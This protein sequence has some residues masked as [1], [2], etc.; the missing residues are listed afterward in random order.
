M[1]IGN[2]IN[3]GFG[4][5][6]KQLKFYCWH[7]K[8]DLD[9]RQQQELV[10]LLNERYFEKLASK[11]RALTRSNID[12]CK[13][14]IAKLLFEQCLTGR[15]RNQLIQ[16]I[17]SDLVDIDVRLDNYGRTLLHRT[18]YNLDVELVKLL[19]DHGVNIRLRDYAGNSALHIAIQSYRNGALIFNNEP[20]V[21]QNLTSI[22]K[23][24]LDA[25]R[26]SQRR[27]AVQKRLK[28]DAER[29]T[30]NEQRHIIKDPGSPKI[31][32]CSQQCK[33]DNYYTSSSIHT[34]QTQQ[35]NLV[36]H[37]ETPSRDD[38]ICRIMGSQFHC[39]IHNNTNNKSKLM[40]SS[41]LSNENRNQESH[42]DESSSDSRVSLATQ[43]LNNVQSDFLSNSSCPLLMEEDL[44][45]PLVDTKNAFG[46]T[47]LHYCVLVVGERHLGHFVQLL[48]SY[49]ADP[50]AIDSRLKTP[51]YCLVKRPSI[52]AVRQKCL[53]IT[54]L[55][56]SGCDDL[57]LAIENPFNYFNEKLIKNLEENISIILQKSNE[58]QVESIFTKTTFKKCPSL[59]HLARLALIKIND[60]KNGRLGRQTGFMLPVE[61]PY[62][63]NHYI[64][65]RVLD[66]S[67][68][69]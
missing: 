41:H 35:T 22:I 5:L 23:L 28:L 53:A 50:D 14:Q 13:Q 1:L 24:L 34:G 3:D 37:S 33:L 46:R 58:E 26:K 38:T 55:L 39:K 45:I 44:N 29:H 56:Q 2:I 42:H 30:I 9:S 47:A 12:D 19:I 20:E 66:Q 59:K 65:R 48:L 61:V 8:R 62:S 15:R 16:L 57:G 51:L 68:L 40:K 43:P 60:E 36:A 25:D 10:D 7:Y 6:S 11:I 49:G 27:H 4:L 67:E 52:S 32:K 69:F 64:N 31:T 63:L 17:E 21:V 18:A 54:N